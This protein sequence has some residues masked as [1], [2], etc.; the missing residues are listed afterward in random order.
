MH[1]DPMLSLR[2]SKGLYVM[3]FD[4]LCADNKKF[5]NYFRMSKSSFFELLSLI[6]VDITGKDTKMRKCI[7][8]EE[9]LVVTL[10]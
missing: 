4:E 9:K 5:F 1:V 7:T 8:P 10:R 6:K 3:M 2:E